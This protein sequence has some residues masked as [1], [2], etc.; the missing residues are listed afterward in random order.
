MVS[1]ARLGTLD[2]LMTATEESMRPIACR[3]REFVRRIDPGAVEFV[4]LGDRAAT[5]GVGPRKMLKGTGASMRHVK[6]RSMGAAGAPAL[7][8]LIR[9][10]LRVRRLALG[11]RA[12]D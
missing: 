9:A 2:E 12:A 1:T 3:L 5:Y 4:R 7:E 6:V 10:A 11:S 8:S